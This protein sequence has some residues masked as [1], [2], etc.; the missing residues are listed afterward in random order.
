MTTKSP[1]VA[2]HINHTCL[3]VR[4]IKKTIDFYKNVFGI[5]EPKIE[6][7]SDQGVLAA[8][9]RIGGSQLEFIQSTDPEGGVARFIER[10]GEGMHHI[11]L[12]VED[13]QGTLDRLDA[14]GLELID[15]VPRE[16]LSGNIAFIHPKSTGGVLL[17]LVDQAT[18]RR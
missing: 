12:E 9:L 16:G 8:L 15:K 17:E 10:K 18:A 7:I 11:C 1:C 5:P 6:E 4:D 13:I 2:R 14:E 3:A